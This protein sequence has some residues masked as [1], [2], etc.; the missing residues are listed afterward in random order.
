MFRENAYRSLRLF[1]EERLSTGGW[2]VPHVCSWYWAIIRSV[3][4]AAVP[5]TL[6]KDPM[7]RYRTAAA[8]LMLC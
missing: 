2:G 8:P 5:T 3:L 7:S 6:G 4:E 1:V